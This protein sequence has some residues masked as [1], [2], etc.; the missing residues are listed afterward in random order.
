M[1]LVA[2]VANSSSRARRHGVIDIPV[3]R[4]I[5]SCDNRQPREAVAGNLPSRNSSAPRNLTTRR[6]RP[7]NESRMKST[8]QRT[9]PLPA[10]P[11]AHPPGPDAYPSAGYSWY[12]VGVLTLAYIFSFIDRQILSLMVGPI[13]TDLGIDDIQMSLLMGAKFCRFLHIFRHSSGPPRRH[14]QPPRDHLGGYRRLEHHDR[15]LWAGQ[16]VLA[17]GRDA[18]GGG[19][20]RGEPFSLGLFAH[21][22]LF[23]AR[24][25]VY[26]DERVFDGHLHRCRLGIHPGRIRDGACAGQDSTVLPWIGPVRSWQLVF[27]VVGLPGLLVSLLL[28]T[29]REPVRMGVPLKADGSPITAPTSQVVWSY[30]R[31]NYATFLCLTL[32][33]GLVA[34]YSYGANA[35]IPAMLI[36]RYAWSRGKTGLVFG[37]IVAVA[38]TLGIVSGGRLADWLRQ[39]GYADS[40]FRIALWGTIAGLPFVLLFPLAPSGNAVAGLLVP[41][42]F[43]MSMPFGVAPAAIQQMMP[44]TMRAQATAVY[45]FVINIVG[46]GLGPTI[47]AALTEKVFRD[48]AGR[49][50]FPAGRGCRVVR[51]RDHSAVGRDQAVSPQSGATG[52]LHA[53]RQSTR[54]VMASQAEP[55]RVEDC[56]C[57]PT[58]PQ[59]EVF[60]AVIA[61]TTGQSS[62]WARPVAAW[63]LRPR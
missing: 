9:E 40:N 49:P 41:A 10:Q 23:P 30:I 13:K 46:I 5:R 21:L 14:A 11:D 26:R 16:D 35:W 31:M 61:I 6:R 58:T 32:G 1:F 3:A 39:R 24:A 43:F 34:L 12:V 38:G 7:G 27:F 22:R 52:T 15:R 36:R 48:T 62:P 19:S 4:T 51:A 20:G 47:V 37:I 17:T 33:T 56:T 44:N 28:L 54:F 53:R 50:S 29:V 42:V 55:K 63:P 25:P 2:V 59:R 45:L 57:G 60:S 8:S 18:H